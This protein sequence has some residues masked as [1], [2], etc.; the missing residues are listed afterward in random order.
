MDSDFTNVYAD[1]ARA[2]AYA[3]LEYP[4][5]YY[6]AFR[7]L[8]GLLRRCPPGSPALDFGCGAGRST[9]YLKDLGFQADGIDISE[10]MLGQ[11]RLRDPEGSYQLV[12]GD[13][14]PELPPEA[15]A[16]V[17]AAFTFDNIPTAATKVALLQALRGS[18]RPEGR[19]VI[20]VSTPEIYYHEWAS[21]S[22]RAFP[23]NREA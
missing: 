8:P 5:T 6:L 13:H 18:L 22:T 12:P 4:G 11:A 10:A 15:Y 7:D 2:Q 19:I 1:P 3:A 17:L 16:L 14:P 9:R 21:F 23:E 20:I